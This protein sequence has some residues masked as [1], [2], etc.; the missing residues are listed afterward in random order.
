MVRKLIEYSVNR[1]IEIIEISDV[2]ENAV[3][4]AKRLVAQIFICD[5]I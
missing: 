2:L 1:E 5:V 4:F 3:N